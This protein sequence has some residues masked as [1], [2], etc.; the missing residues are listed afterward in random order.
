MAETIKPSSPAPASSSIANLPAANIEAMPAA[1]NAEDG[2]RGDEQ[3]TEPDRKRGNARRGGRGQQGKRKDRGDRGDGDSSSKGDRSRRWNESKRRKVDDRGNRVAFNKDGERVKSYMSIPFSEEE[4]AAEE[5]RPKRKVAVMIGYAGT[6]YKGM[7]I[8]HQ[9]KTIEG[10]LFAAF[11]AAGAVSKANASDPR[12]IALVRCARTDK[13]VHAAGNVISLKLIIEDPDIVQKINESLPEQIRVWGME[14]TNN[15][16]SAYTACDSRWYEYLLPS[17]ALLPPH[18]DSF[19]GRKVSDAAKENG[20]YDDMLKRWEDVK[21]FWT[22]VEENDIKPMLDNIDPEL[23][24]EV[25][26]L[27]HAADEFR[28]I[29][30]KEASGSADDEA[31][32]E[33]TPADSEKPSGEGESKKSSARREFTAA[34]IA[35]RDVKAA[36]R[37]ALRRYRITAVRLQQ[38]QEALNQYVGTRN[39]HNY[40]VQKT[41]KD[42]SAKRHIKSFVVNPKPIQ[43]RD[44]EWLSL[45]VHGQSFMM[46]QIRKMVAMA[47]LVVRCGAPLDRITESYGPRNIS[48]PKVPGSGLLLERPVFEAYNQK[49]K[50]SFGREPIS[51]EKYEAQIEEFKNRQIY[52]RMWEAEEK[53]NAFHDFFRQIDNFR[54]DYFLWVTANGITGSRERKEK[55]ENIP[56]ELEAELGEDENPEE[57]DG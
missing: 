11:V 34:E 27:L 18:P 25:L 53:E 12:K 29:D 37:T 2:E 16:F 55:E 21:D 23:R 5:R 52:P 31:K 54:S 14:R 49:A 32:T 8:A 56:K 45:K 20:V 17:Y 48:I 4:I 26:S 46:H 13:G 40:T 50:E 28:N 39:F 3:S 22:D 43:I 35:A 30:T 33:I 42:P 24:K 1:E 15:S 44:T 19:L 7:Q 38:L 51:F 57:G 36:Y 6:G 47:C 10:E 41:H 9:E